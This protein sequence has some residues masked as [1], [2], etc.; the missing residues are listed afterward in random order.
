MCIFSLVQKRIPG[1][2]H[3]VCV[4]QPILFGSLSDILVV[5]GMRQSIVVFLQ[6]WLLVILNL[7]AI[8]IFVILT[9]N[10]CYHHWCQGILSPFYTHHFT[11]SITLHAQKQLPQTVTFSLHTL[12]IRK[13]ILLNIWVNLVKLQ[14]KTT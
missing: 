12:N 10:A 3:K 2:T 13:C 9:I 7:S 4:L 8:Y 14:L 6:H 1:L 5:L 11:C